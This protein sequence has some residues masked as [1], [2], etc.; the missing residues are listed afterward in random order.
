MVTTTIR[1]SALGNRSSLSWPG[2]SAPGYLLRDRDCIYGQT[3]SDATASLNIREVLTAPRSPW[4][5]PYV[6]R[7]IGS[8]RRECLDHV[9]IISNAGLSRILKDYFEY[10]ERSRTHLSLE[11]DAPISRP[12]QPP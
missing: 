1:K 3:F 9:I 11:K 4:Q 10:Y 5:N 7:F 2:G 8:I 12:I 6:E